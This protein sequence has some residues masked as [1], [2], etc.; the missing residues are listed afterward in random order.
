MAVI[1]IQRR[2]CVS[3]LLRISREVYRDDE[4][5]ASALAREMIH[6]LLLCNNAFKADCVPS[7][8]DM[9]YQKFYLG[10]Q[11]NARNNVLWDVHVP[12]HGADV[13]ES[14]NH[15]PISAALNKVQSRE[16]TLAEACEAAITSEN[17]SRSLREWCLAHNL[18][19]ATVKSGEVEGSRDY[20]EQVSHWVRVLYM[21]GTKLKMGESE[22]NFV[23]SQLR[24]AEEIKVIGPGGADNFIYDFAI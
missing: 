15:D 17:C 8:M 3:Q 23:L 16:W 13:I 18:L 7:E 1:K 2:V 12:M 5:R 6:D 21:H 22:M 14:I 9:Y 19:V 11:Y 20:K 4:A 10:K 24:E